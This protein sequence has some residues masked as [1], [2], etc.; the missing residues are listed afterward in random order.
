MKLKGF[1][2]I[3][4]VISL[5]IISLLISTAYISYNQIIRHSERITFYNSANKHAMSFLHAY[6]Q[7]PKLFNMMDWQKAE[8]SAQFK[9]NVD[10][11]DEKYIITFSK[12]TGARSWQKQF[13][14]IKIDNE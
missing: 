3:E 4:T 6:H 1:S 2:Y 12:T 10:E 8:G 5:I 11:Q 7:N 14:F 9:I 13:K